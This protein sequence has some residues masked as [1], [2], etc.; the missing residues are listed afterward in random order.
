MTEQNFKAA[1]GGRII[2]SVQ[3]D[4]PGI[5]Y[6]DADPICR[7]ATIRATTLDAEGPTADAVDNADV[8]STPD[9]LGLRIKSPYTDRKSGGLVE[10]RATVPPGS[11]AV[12]QTD[13]ADITML[14]A[15]S[16]D[17]AHADT[18]SGQVRILAAGSATAVTET[19]S[20]YVGSAATVDATSLGA[21]GIPDEVRVRIDRADA[22]K[23]QTGAGDVHV[24]YAA[25]RL[26]V[27]TGEGSIKADNLG[28]DSKLQSQG[29]QITATVTG[30]GDH[31]IT[32][33]TAPVRVTIE[34]S[35]PLDGVRVQ[36]IDPRGQA[37]VEDNRPYPASTGGA[38]AG[39][40]A[41]QSTGAGV[42]A[43]PAAVSPSKWR[44]NGTI[45]R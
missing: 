31:R 5:V 4:C 24:G 35:A 21:E 36:A 27:T 38:A 17:D 34:R 1:A 28:G 41:T 8:S 42:A 13:S 2:L 23:V 14:G 11:S 19:G 7:Q 20:I 45:E 12:V 9:G 39:A 44:P 22:A 30:P 6:V 18:K 26:E 29:G 43:G 16:L 3:L 37:Q 33:A 10:V 32:S 25:S 15:G 40:A